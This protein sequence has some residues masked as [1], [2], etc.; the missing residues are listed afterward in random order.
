MNWNWDHLRFFL[1]LANAGS[2]TSA[3]KELGVSHTTV[4]RRIRSMESELETHLF[5]HTTQGHVLTPA[6]EKLH[7][8]VKK[9]KTAVDDIAR[10][11][12]GMDQRIEG[13]VVI[14]TTDTLG[15][16]FAPG[17]V[18]ALVQRYPQLSIVLRISNNLADISNREADIALRTGLAPPEQ[19]VGRKIASLK[20]S[21]CASSRYVKEHKLDSFP[22]STSEHRFIGFERE[23]KGT[24]FCD[25]LDSKLAPNAN[26]VTASGLLT[27][28][29]LCS[30]DVGITV[31]PTY[32][33]ESSDDLVELATD[34]EI[35]VN[36][37][38]L[39]SH[40]DLR[41]TLRIRLVKQFVIEYFDK[42]YTSE[43][44]LRSGKAQ[45]KD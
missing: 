39:L 42:Q 31:L 33:V 28:Y 2:L 17:L 3:A 7:H 9:M 19:L 29:H 41:D 27:A 44:T 15:Y 5:D 20:F 45:R 38:W 25:W 34:E 23:L 36:G 35:A 8:E 24:P 37:L 12:S 40:V 10:Q 13:P 11:V 21:A 4:L 18:N 26:R 43:M 22:K 32:L 6:G 30:A 16:I 14:T 1:A